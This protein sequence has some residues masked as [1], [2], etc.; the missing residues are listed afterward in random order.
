MYITPRGEQTPRVSKDGSTPSSL[1]PSNNA[2]IIA[3]KE[4]EKKRNGTNH[5]NSSRH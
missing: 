3:N 2:G 4:K 1:Q 5:K